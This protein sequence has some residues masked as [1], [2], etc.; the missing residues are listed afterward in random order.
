MDTTRIYWP[1]DFRRRS[2]SKDHSYVHSVLWG[3]AFKLTVE[4]L[5]QQ[6]W[7]QK[8]T[9]CFIKQG[10]FEIVW[11]YEENHWHQWLLQKV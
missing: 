6:V 1:S 3:F 8:I 10:Y 2:I 4:K 9:K 11:F 7:Q 5:W